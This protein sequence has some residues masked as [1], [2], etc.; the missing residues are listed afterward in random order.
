MCLC[1]QGVCEVQR[2]RVCDAGKELL[3]LLV[4]ILLRLVAASKAGI[5]GYELLEASLLD[6][7]VLAFSLQKQRFGLFVKPK[8]LLVVLEVKVTV[9]SVL[10]QDSVVVL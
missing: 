6:F 8:R 4:R 10:H 7:S 3:L 2:R 1:G 5:G 9:G